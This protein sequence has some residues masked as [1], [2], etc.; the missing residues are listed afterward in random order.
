[1]KGLGQRSLV[2]LHPLAFEEGDH[3]SHTL[4]EDIFPVTVKVH[5]RAAQ[6][7]DNTTYPH[8]SN[9]ASSFSNLILRL[10]LSLGVT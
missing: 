5:Q 6:V 9:A 2:E 3:I 7:E 4:T 1:M 8:T 10:L